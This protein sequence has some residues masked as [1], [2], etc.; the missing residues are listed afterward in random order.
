MAN[1]IKVAIRVRPQL[2]TEVVDACVACPSETTISVS[3]QNDV[4]CFSFDY[5]AGQTVTQ[6]EVFQRIGIDL[7][8]SALERYNSTLFV[9]GQTG[10]G[11]TYT[12]FGLCAAL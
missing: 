9:Y 3:T 7:V 5:V 6:E 10:S 2:E 12:T 11:K 1:N 4:Q 8:D